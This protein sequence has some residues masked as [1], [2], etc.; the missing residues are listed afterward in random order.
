MLEIRKPSDLGP[1]LVFYA[2]FA[3]RISTKIHDLI[4]IYGFRINTRGPDYCN[5]PSHPNWSN[6]ECRLCCLGIASDGA[7][8]MVVVVDQ[9]LALYQ[10]G[11]P[12]NDRFVPLDKPLWH[13]PLE[14]D[15][16]DP[17]T[18]LRIVLELGLR[19][20]VCTSHFC[21][22]VAANMLWVIGFQSIINFFM[23]IVFLMFIFC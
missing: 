21:K 6:H 9:S 17:L 14:G 19:L 16:D 1:T 12:S 10:L 7:N 3:F 20:I 4:P 11:H 8:L 18:D 5:F 2:N 15:A 23:S 13:I 22:F